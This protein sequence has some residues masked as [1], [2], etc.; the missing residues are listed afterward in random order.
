MVLTR[1]QEVMEVNAYKLQDEKKSHDFR[2]NKVLVLI[3][4]CLNSDNLH[5]KLRHNQSNN[6]TYAKLKGISIYGKSE[7]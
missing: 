5:H 2:A 1:V 7:H 6:R 3:I 4:F